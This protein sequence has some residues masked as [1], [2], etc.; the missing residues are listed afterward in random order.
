MQKDLSIPA[1]TIPYTL[2]RSRRARHVRLTVYGDG[3]VVL[4]SPA[5]VGEHVAE[6]FIREHAEWLTA[7]LEFFRKRRERGDGSGSDA[8]PAPHRRPRF[9][10]A[11]YLRNKPR[12]LALVREKVARFVAVYDLAQPRSISIRN[13]RT[14]WGSC[15]RRGN[16][17]FS[18]KIVLL[19]PRAQDYLIVHELC[20]LA[21]FNHSPRFWALVARAVPEYKEIR[22]KMRHQTPR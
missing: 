21:E 9:T 11:D 20:H 1:G 18:W 2:R 10:R 3:R 14:R 8:G 5:G 22:K 15:S 13:Q 16:L 7:K 17:S 19:T 12:A 6:R 4:T